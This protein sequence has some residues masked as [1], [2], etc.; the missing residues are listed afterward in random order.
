MSP[1]P[2]AAESLTPLIVPG[3][4][5]PSTN[6]FSGGGGVF[7]HALDAA[8]AIAAS[9]ATRLTFA[10]LRKVIAVSMSVAARLPASRVRDGTAL[11]RATDRCH[12]QLC[13]AH[14]VP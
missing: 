11:F 4:T 7:E 8:A 9:R 1:W 13:I 14:Q 6:A 2:H 12:P 10:S 5:R 3:P